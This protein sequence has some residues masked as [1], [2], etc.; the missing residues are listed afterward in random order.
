MTP[1]V[2]LSY[3]LCSF[4]SPSLFFVQ[5]EPVQDTEGRIHETVQQRVPPYYLVDAAPPSARTAGINTS[6]IAGIDIRKLVVTD[7][8]QGAC[9]YIYI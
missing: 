9:S 4:F 3:L 6:I 2:T 8:D 7:I 5:N 1:C